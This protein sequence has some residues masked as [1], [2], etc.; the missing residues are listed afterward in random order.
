MYGDLPFAG[1]TDRDALLKEYITGKGHEIHFNHDMQVLLRD[2]NGKL[3]GAIFSTNDGLVQINAKSTLLATGG[4]PAN[5]QMVREINPLATKCVT[6]DGYMPNCDGYGIRAA[7]WI[8]AAK[9]VEPAP[10]IFDRS[11][12]LPGEDAGHESDADDAR[13]NSTYGGIGQFVLGSQPFMKVSRNGIRFANEST[14]YDFM[15]FA[16]SEQPGGVYASIFDSNAQEDVARFSTIGCSKLG[17]LALLSGAPIDEVFADELERGF[18]IKADTI[19][20]LADGLGFSD[21]SKAAFLG[22]VERYNGYFDNQKDEEYGKEAYRLSAIR[23]APYYGFWLGGT[24]LTTIDGLKIN[25]DMQV[26]DNNAQVIEGLYAAGDCSGSLFSGNY[27][28]LL[29]G[30]ACGRT[31]T[32]G[33]H[34]VRH[35][36]GAL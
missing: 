21:E 19:E 28:E 35:I 7:M 12:A 9:D 5:R 30:C 11:I 14:P 23:Q 6:A 33:R 15:P 27:P 26:L 1:T 25:E 10:M 8:G 20:G 4:Y 13:F 36:A 32:F 24:L 18:L 17:A 22:Q 29:V 16:A 31:I 34:A 2:D 3:T